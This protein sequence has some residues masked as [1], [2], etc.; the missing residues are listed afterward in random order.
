MTEVN[1][2]VAFRDRR[3][4]FCEKSF[5]RAFSLL[6]GTHRPFM[7]E[8][9][10]RPPIALIA[11]ALVAL[12]VLELTLPSIAEAACGHGA[13]SK[14]QRDDESKFNHIY[15]LSMDQRSHHETPRGSGR[16][17][18]SGPSCSDGSS[19]GPSAPSP[20]SSET[21][22]RWLCAAFRPDTET[23]DGSRPRLLRASPHPVNRAIALER[24]PRSLPV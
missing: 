17:P 19:P 16:L 2:P 13:L 15:I 23:P 12:A 18:C 24:P 8:L 3:R 20:E 1:E 22:E 5:S 9:F 21:H 6:A 10:P 11:G 7:T 4:V 14:T